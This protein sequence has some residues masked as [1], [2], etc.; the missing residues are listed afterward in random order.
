[1]FAQEY[2]EPTVVPD[3]LSTAEGEESTAA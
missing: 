2:A 3:Q 1:M